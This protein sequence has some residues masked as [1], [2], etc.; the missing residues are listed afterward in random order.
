MKKFGFLALITLLTASY[1]NANGPWKILFQN[2]KL[3]S[4]ALMEHYTWV[5]PAASSA[6]YLLSGAA[7]SS[8]A[9]T[10]ITSFTHSS[11]DFPRNIVLTPTGTT[12]NVGSGTAVVSGTNIFGK[13]ISENFAI[14]SSQSTATTGNKAFKSVT[15]VVFPKASSSGVTLSIGFGTK[16]GLIHCLNNAGDYVFSEYGGAYETTRGTQAVSSTA[17]ESNTFIPNG[18]LDGA[19]NIDEFYVQNFRCYGN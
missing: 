1:A 17:V 18:S 11:P 15:S 7:I 4:Q 5:N 13:A 16:L 10:T 2:E 9:A 12:S 3:P 8:A 19:H 14:S 6:S